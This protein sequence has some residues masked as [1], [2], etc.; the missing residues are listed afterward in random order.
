MN[1]LKSYLLLIFIFGLILTSCKKIDVPSDTPV[2]IK[3]KIRKL[4]NEDCPSVKTVYQYNFQGQTVYAFNPKDCG[5]DLSS[6]IVDNNCNNICWLGG[7]S[8]NMV[9]NGDTFFKAAT[10]ERLI[11]QDN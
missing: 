4:L 8:G 6:E 1:P 3:K 5:A 11:W 9:C 10:N 7:I 2:C